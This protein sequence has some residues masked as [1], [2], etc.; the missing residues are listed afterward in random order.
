MS[1][2]AKKWIPIAKLKKYSKLKNGYS[3]YPSSF[4]GCMFEKNET[5]A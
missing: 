3:Q 2:D 4:S 1:I 5:I